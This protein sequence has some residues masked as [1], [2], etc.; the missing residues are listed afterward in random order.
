MLRLSLLLIA[1]IGLAGAWLPKCHGQFAPGTKFPG[2]FV[3]PGAAPTEPGKDVA[4]W[5]RSLQNFF[6][7]SPDQRSQL[8]QVDV[9]FKEEKEFG[10]RVYS[11]LEQS[12]K[13]QK[14]G[15]IQR[16]EDVR[17][18]NQLVARVQ[19]LMNQKSRYQ[20]LKICL[21]DS[22]EVDACSIPGGTL[23]FTRGL[24]GSAES[25][26]ALVGIVAHEL[27]HLDRQH[28][29]KPLQQQRLAEKQFSGKPGGN[30]S[31]N[32]DL[33]RFFDF[34]KISLASFH[35]IH[36]EEESE[37]D[38]DATR[39]MYELGYD[40]LQLAKLFDRLSEKAKGQAQMLPAFLRSHPLMRDRSAK[41]LA[42]LAEL[43]KAS[44]KN[45]LVVGAQALRDRSPAKLPK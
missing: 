1:S 29:L 26:A 10:D 28:Q 45:D 8:R 35:S 15:V 38:S 37:A 7:L 9:P 2:G 3:V 21:V 42:D 13:Q 34:G 40:P 30:P 44:P 31:G 23:V 11:Q 39:W 19:P 24:L 4:D 20:K 17:Y 36:P 32:F 16:G 43:Q 5:D 18:L 25:E 12:F 33:N 6:Q 14:V 22:D 41:V 27:S